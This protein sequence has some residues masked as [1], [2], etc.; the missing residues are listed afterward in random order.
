MRKWQLIT[1]S[2]LILT[3]AGAL[4]AQE[5]GTFQRSAPERHGGGWEQRW[6]LESPVKDGARLMLR[7]ESGAV[8]IRPEGAGALKCVVVLRAD[9][10]DEAAARRL[11]DEL[12][13]SVK[14]LEGGGLYITSEGP[15]HRRHGPGVSVQFHLT[16]PQRFNVDIE[17]QGGD[18]D[19]SNAL[20]GEAKLTTAGGNVRVA[21]ISG[22]LRIETAGGNI[23]L[24]KVGG[25]LEARTAGGS[26]H[27][28]DVG[29][30]A[31]LETS[32]GEISTGRVIGTLRAE[33]AGG[34]LVIGGAGGQLVAQTA[35]GQISVGPSGGSVRAETAG[36]S[37]RLHGA[38]GRVVVET[39]GGSIDLL[40][41]ESAV[42]AST[43]AGRILAQFNCTKQSFGP[44]ELATSMG[45]VFV[46][47]P[48][49]VPLTIDAAID[50][51]AGHRIISDFPLVVQGQEEVVPST[52]RG[53]G[54]LLGGGE[55]L[56]IRTVSGNIE[57]RKLDAQSLRDMEQRESTNWKAWDERRTEKQ[58]R[59][60]QRVREL[61]QKKDQADEN[62]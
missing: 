19:V 51:A 11:F 38:R 22:L 33:T 60:E 1:Y 58:Q 2:T 45:D 53:H 29:A 35:G 39:E 31:S 56:K 16:V 57:I 17:T 46:Y 7:A 10:S 43:S 30:D 59:S 25:K 41:V 14:T 24:N 44:S 6:T 27:V 5:A 42:R 21:D 28:G 32:G 15:G 8:D 34:D 55:I 23:S 48:V 36:G 62:H 4:M 26:I 47:L 9:R 49:N 50:A 61:Q 52:I 12:H 40:N 20:T 13:A 37:I 3:T 18:V 54:A